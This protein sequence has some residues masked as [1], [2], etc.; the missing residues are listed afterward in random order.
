[1]DPFSPEPDFS[2]WFGTNSKSRKV[3]QIK[4]N[5]AVSIYYLDSDRSGYVLIYGKAELV[6]DASEKEKHWK[7][8]WE[9]FYP[10]RDENYTLIKVIPEW[11]EVLSDKHG[12]ANNPITWEPPKV[13]FNLE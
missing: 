2:V 3:E 10:N 6:N 1:M 4:K 8:A 12:V 7:T 13:Y 9:A 11:M 5:D